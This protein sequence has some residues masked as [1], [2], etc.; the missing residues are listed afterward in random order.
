M[1]PPSGRPTVVRW[2]TS[3]ASDIAAS[4]ANRCRGYGSGALYEALKL[5]CRRSI[6]LAAQPLT[7]YI[8]AI[9]SHVGLSTELKTDQEM[10]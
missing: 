2:T 3:A 7:P 10:A 6:S 8:M 4:L 1:G 5:L 9:T